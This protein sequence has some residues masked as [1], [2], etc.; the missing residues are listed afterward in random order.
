M[1][2]DVY[3]DKEANETVIVAKKGSVTAER[4]LPGFLLG[5]SEELKIRL[6]K[7]AV[8]EEINYGEI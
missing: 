2:I 6:A 8:M 1:T 7:I 3:Y 5:L 4:R